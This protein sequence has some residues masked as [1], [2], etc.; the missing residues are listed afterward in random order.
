MK[1]RSQYSIIN[2]NST[3]QTEKLTTEKKIIN[4]PFIVT[5]STYY[6]RQLRDDGQFFPQII[7]PYLVWIA[8]ILLLALDQKSNSGEAKRVNI[9]TPFKKLVHK[10]Y[11]KA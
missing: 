5:K 4:F 11:A 2:I 1:K 6:I 7:V 10:A 9:F 8:I 3:E